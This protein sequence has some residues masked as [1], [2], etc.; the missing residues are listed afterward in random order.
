MRYFYTCLFALFFITNAYAQQF[1]W[2][3]AGGT[4]DNIIASNQFEAAIYSTTDA[5]G[6]VYA[7]SRIGYGA[8]QA[9]TFTHPY[10]AYGAN[11]NFLVASYNPHGQM[12]WAKLIGSSNSECLAQ[13]IAA[14]SLGHIYVAG[15]LSNGTLHIGY[16]TTIGNALI[17][18]REGL[19]QFDTSGHFNWIRYVGNN[20][21]TTFY[22][23]GTGATGSCLAGDGSSN[24]THLITYV[25]SGVQVTPTIT[26]QTGTYDLTYDPSGDLLSAKRLEMDSVWFINSSV[27]DPVSNKLFIVG[28]RDVNLPPY[29][30]FAAAFDINRNKI[31]MDTISNGYDAIGSIVY[32]RIGHL[33]FDGATQDVFSFNG[34]FVPA[35]THS[36]IMKTD[37][38]GHP[39]WIQYNQIN[40]IG[41]NA[42]GANTLTL[43]PN[44]LIAATGIFGTTLSDGIHSIT[45]NSVGQNPFLSIL[46]TSG[47]PMTL[48]ELYGDGIADWSTS[49]TSDRKGNIYI[50]GQV[51]DSIYA[52]TIHAFHSTGG[53]TD[54]FVMRYG[55]GD[56]CTAMPVADFSTMLSQ[57]T[58]NLTYT[59][60]TTGIDSLVWNFGDGSMGNGNSV[61]HTYAP[62][63]QGQ[64][65]TYEICVTAYSSCGQDMHCSRV[66]IYGPISVNNIALADDVQVFPNP[67]T[68]ELNIKA[69]T[70][71]TYQLMSITGATLKTGSLQAGSN[72]ISVSGLAAGIY[73]FEVK[74]F[75][76]TLKVT[77]VVKE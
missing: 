10:G 39:I 54:F 30:S 75:D 44:N 29:C 62:V 65:T 26:S 41:T 71:K 34:M 21:A 35:G 58:E 23:T 36:L 2:V 76:G 37:T 4:P 72:I 32:D 50:G 17:Y 63:P 47:V 3:R 22:G 33:Y 8:V 9:D 1:D 20:T 64:D 31:W 51:E 27:I 24:N 28:S 7:I 57:Y 53:N 74:S 69:A 13:G 25:R 67:A 19:I 66:L 6:N 38:S 52:D 42:Y 49:L 16:D 5:N 60:T 14:D 77:R 43:L 40:N 56:E 59:G 18:E 48:K 68:A 46:D 61:S 55:V 45:N 73:L 11:P 12:R 70:A 15:L